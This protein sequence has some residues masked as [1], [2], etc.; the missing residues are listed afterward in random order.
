MRPEGPP[1]QHD[2]VEQ[3]QP[4]LWLTLVAVAL[5]VAYLIAFVLENTTKVSVHWVFATT[6]GSLIWVVV[7]SL[8]IGLLLGV[9]LSQLYRRHWRRSHLRPGKSLEPGRDAADSVG[10]LTDGSEAVRETR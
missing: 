8:A 7:V 3:W 4:R 10:D 1:A 6:H 5:S 9:L 2:H